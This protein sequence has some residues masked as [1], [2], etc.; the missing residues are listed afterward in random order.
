[1]PLVADNTSM[2]MVVMLV[3]MLAAT[4]ITAFICGIK[5]GFSMMLVAF[6]AIWFLPTV[7]IY[8]SSS[9][10]VYTVIYAAIAAAGCAFGGRLHGKR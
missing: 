7:F 10:L 5:N 4:F 6:V 9:A 1:M 3:V 2:A 8:Y